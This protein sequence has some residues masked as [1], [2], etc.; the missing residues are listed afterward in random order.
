MSARTA[1]AREAYWIIADHGTLLAT[2]ADTGGQFALIEVVAPPGPESGPPLH[3]HTREDEA[4]YVIEGRL[5]VQVADKELELGPGGYAFGPRGVPHRF[6]NPGPGRVK[7]LV[8]V[9]PAGLEK[10]FREAGRPAIA[11]DYTTGFTPPTEALVGRVMSVFAKYGGR[12][13]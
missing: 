9:T 12:G 10:F 2:G 7:F 1:A 4:F 3:V 5:R 13:A 8:L 6:W 11:G